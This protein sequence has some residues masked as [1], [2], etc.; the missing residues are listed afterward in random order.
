MRRRAILSS[1][2]G[3]VLNNFAKKPGLSG[4]LKNKL[5]VDEEEYNRRKDEMRPFV[6]GLISKYETNEE[7]ELLD[8]ECASGACPIR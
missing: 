1:I 6:P 8:D 4:S 5:A 3:C 2:G 7:T